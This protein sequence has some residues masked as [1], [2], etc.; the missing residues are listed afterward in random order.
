[1]TFFSHTART[2]VSAAALLAGFSLF[3]L[4]QS[5]RVAHALPPSAT[6]EVRSVQGSFYEVGQIPVTVARINA[7][8]LP[9]GFHIAKYAEIQNPR[10]I[11][12]APDGTAYVS[13]RD[14]G[15]VRML[16]DTNGDGVAD[17][18]K[19]VFE[20]KQTH[21]L[22]IHN[23]SMYIVTVKEVFVVPIKADG[24]LG[25]AKQIIGDLPD[26]GQHFNR[27]LSVGPDEKLYIAVGSTTNV[28]NETNKEN[29]T[30]LRCNLDGTNRQ[31]FASGLRN[32]IGFGWHPSAKRFW[33][34]DQGIDWLGD[35][36]QGEEFNEIV[37]GQKYG[38][39][40]VYGK[41]ELH[42]HLRPPMEVGLTNADWAKQ[43]KEPELLY[44]AHS[45]GIQMAF[46]TGAM[47]PKE[48]QND[49]FISLRG[50]WNRNPPSGYEVARVHFDASGKATKIEPF[51]TG[52]LVKGADPARNGRDAQFARLAG[53]AVAKDGS[54]LVSDD[55]NGTIY[56]VWYGRDAVMPPITRR[57]DISLNLPETKP[58]TNAKITVTSP[59][60]KNN[61]P[62]PDE[63]TDYFAGTF[64]GLSWS[65]APAGTQAFAVMVEDPDASTKPITH[66]V[67]VFPSSVTQLDAGL[68][69]TDTLANGGMQGG[70]ATGA[71]GYYG[72][73]PPAADKPHNYHFQVF[74]LDTMPTLPTG[75]NRQA[76]LDAINGHVLAKG[77]TVGTYKRTPDVRDKP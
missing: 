10:I 36:E 73:H 6:S 57:E 35:D 8:K 5:G 48:Y 29:A 72:P 42:P 25:E 62:I 28:A 55:S 14:L 21:G 34:W 44:T 58:K 59:A 2:G 60:F 11:A 74:A 19:T 54:L 13:S 41:S 68:P 24:T 65:N 31:I 15:T 67:G 30:M 27:V 61:G 52:F 50:S 70:N 64:P 3:S 75:F 12:V 33:G 37:E 45:A 7:L 26:G 49:A 47:F 71:V 66:F 32:T 77:E 63:N 43:S 53:C 1:M 20:H 76:V 46:Y 9:P 51:L 69:K 40:Y 22:A 39:P 17:I 18:Q 4:V 38:W 56:R 23:G 16:K